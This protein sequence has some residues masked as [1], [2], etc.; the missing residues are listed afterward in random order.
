MTK[1][2]L[3]Q[4]STLVAEG[5]EFEEECEYFAVSAVLN[6]RKHLSPLSPVVLNL[7]DEMGSSM[8][9]AREWRRY[10]AMLSFKRNLVASFKTGNFSEVLLQTLAQKKSF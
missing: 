7:T 5:D 8:R 2:L 9:R 1:I 3:P 10:L 6:F 4:E